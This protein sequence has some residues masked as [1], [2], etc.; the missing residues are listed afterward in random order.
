MGVSFCDI[1]ADIIRRPAQLT[2]LH[3]SPVCRLH[4]NRRKMPGKFW[5]MLHTVWKHLKRKGGPIRVYAADLRWS[6][7]FQ[8]KLTNVVC[9]DRSLTWKVAASSP[10]APAESQVFITSVISASQRVERQDA[11]RRHTRCKNLMWNLTLVSVGSCYS[12][13]LRSVPSLNKSAEIEINH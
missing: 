5:K 9:L 7:L 10:E 11:E 13:L 8:L 12:R 1:T 6:H 2:T 4:H 3:V